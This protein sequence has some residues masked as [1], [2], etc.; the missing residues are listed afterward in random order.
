MPQG[1]ALQLKL[2]GQGDYRREVN[3]HKPILPTIAT[4]LNTHSRGDTPR[5]DDKKKRDIPVQ[6][7]LDLEGVTSVP[8]GSR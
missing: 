2:L 1:T 6:L 7:C 5:N 3:P 8:C 4:W